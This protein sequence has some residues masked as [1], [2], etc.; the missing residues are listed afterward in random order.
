MKSKSTEEK[1]YIFSEYIEDNFNELQKKIKN[2]CKK[3]LIEFDE[4]IFMDTILKCLTNF[5]KG[6]NKKDIEIY[7][8]KA[9][10]QN[11]YSKL[12]RDISSKT[13]DIDEYDGDIIDEEYNEDIDNIID[14]FKK[15]IIKKFGSEIYD[16]WLLHVCNNYT[17][18]KLEECGYKGLNLHNEFR[19]IKRYTDKLMLS[20]EKIKTLLKEN[21]FI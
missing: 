10:K 9:F 16:A 20:D 17:Y 21:N 18:T 5:N 11:I 4:D 15:E 7:F 12:S 19:Q 1:I 6:N 8:W 14:Y 3:E 13:T 2:K